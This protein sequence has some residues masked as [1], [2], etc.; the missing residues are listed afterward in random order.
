MHVHWVLLWLSPVH[1]YRSDRSASFEQSAG[2]SPLCLVSPVS[3]PYSY[4]LHC[5]SVLNKRRLS[6]VTECLWELCPGTAGTCTHGLDT[7]AAAHRER[8]QWWVAIV[9]GAQCRPFPETQEGQLGGGGGWQAADLDCCRKLAAPHTLALSLTP[10]APQAAVPNGLSP[11]SDL[12][13]PILPVPTSLPPPPLAQARPRSQ[14]SGQN[15]GST[16]TLCLDKA[17]HAR[18]TCDSQTGI[19]IVSHD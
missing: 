2:A 17:V 9:R 19:N 12:H 8:Q 14:K 11:P 15:G 18:D 3:H 4:G 5:L 16:P 7:P 10:F 1:P 6:A 13:R